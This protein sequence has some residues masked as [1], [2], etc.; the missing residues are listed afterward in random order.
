[1]TAID[2]LRHLPFVPHTV[3]SADAI[4]ALD[5]AVA[6]DPTASFKLKL[7]DGTTRAF[8]VAPGLTIVIKDPDTFQRCFGSG[9]PSQFAEGYID[10]RIDV[11]GAIDEATATVMA[12]RSTPVPLRG[13]LGVA[14]H[15][16]PATTSHTVTEDARDVRAHYDLPGEFFRLFLDEQL[17]YSCG[18]FAS[19]DESIDQAQINKLDLICRKL[20]LTPSDHLVD[21]GCGW[22]ALVIWAAQHYG[23]RAHG[24]TLSHRQAAE[25]SRRVKAAGVDHLVTVGVAHYE[26]LPERMFTKAASVGMYEHVGLSRL[27]AYLTAVRRS[28]LPGGA[29]LH[30]GITVPGGERM[31]TGGE[32]MLREVFP[33]SEIDTAPHL[34][35]ALEAAGFEVTD[36]HNMRPHYALTLRRWFAKFQAHRTRAVAL[37]SERVAR[38]WDVYLAGSAEGFERGLLGLHQILAVTPGAD[39]TVAVPL[40]RT[41]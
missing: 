25:A 4:E 36:V 8:G 1:M 22:G 16:S 12:L 10:G 13:R 23:A 15:V 6:H 7:W 9:D 17:V 35:Q 40:I 32:F 26:D 14:A 21:V 30:H 33:G 19:P 31:K 37:T 28:L 39:G 41:T 3:T 24:V 11:E 29:Y 38:T 2:I 27:P 5:A 18:Y 34:Q 20:R